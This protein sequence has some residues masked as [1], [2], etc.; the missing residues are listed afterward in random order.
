[1]EPTGTCSQD[2]KGNYFDA[3]D[4]G[5]LVAPGLCAIN[6]GALDAG[7]ELRV[8]VNRRR[9]N[10]F[11]SFIFETGTLADRWLREQATE[12]A[13]G[14]V[15]AATGGLASSAL[16]GGLVGEGLSV[17]GKL[18]PLKYGKQAGKLARQMAA[19]GW[20]DG[21]IREAVASGQRFQ[22]INKATGNPAIRFVHPG[23]GLSM[24][25]DTITKEIIHVGGR[26]FLY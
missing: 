18:A 17:T 7:V 10:A 6:K 23:T 9:S 25:V 1:V 14:A 22:T 12:M 19:R 8:S 3:D 16:S 13:V 4:A 15:I 20:T 24:V 5:T 2:A 21:M 26:G 11:D